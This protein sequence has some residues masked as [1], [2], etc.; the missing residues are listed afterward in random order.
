LGS[1][2]ED[3]RGEH[4]SA[5]YKHMADKED[6]LDGM[7]DLVIGEIDPAIPGAD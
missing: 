6:L 4:S 5:L 7:V 1:A 2:P 3:T